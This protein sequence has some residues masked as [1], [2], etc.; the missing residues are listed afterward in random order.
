MEF[1][2]CTFTR[3]DE[4]RAKENQTVRNFTL[5][6]KD[7]QQNKIVRDARRAQYASTRELAMECLESDGSRVGAARTRVGMY[8]WL[9]CLAEVVNLNRIS[10]ST[11]GLP[12]TDGRLLLT[13][14]GAEAQ[15]A[16]SYL[17]ARDRDS[18]AYFFIVTDEMSAHLY[19]TAGWQ[20]YLHYSSTRRKLLKDV[21]VTEKMKTLPISI[22]MGHGHVQQVAS[23]A[24]NSALGTKAT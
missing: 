13:G 20:C 12:K 14:H 22:F 15:T 9:G 17:V 8:V 3:Q 18:S 10:V 4:F 23:A 7:E 21:F 5:N 1:A 6:M 24:E 11:R 19:V 2:R 16:H